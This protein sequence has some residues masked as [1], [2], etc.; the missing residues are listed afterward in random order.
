LHAWRLVSRASIPHLLRPHPSVSHRVSHS[1]CE[2]SCQKA[3][4]QGGRGLHG[5]LDCLA[6]LIPTIG[7]GHTPPPHLVGASVP[8]ARIYIAGQAGRTHGGARDTRNGGLAVSHVRS[9]TSQP[10]SPVP[11][12]QPA[13]LPGTSGLGFIEQL[14]AR[15]NGVYPLCGVIFCSLCGE[16]RAWPSPAPGWPAAPPMGTSQC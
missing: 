4:G 1:L 5:G 14:T 7:Y 11:H 6:A 2:I 10:S 3:V 9:H 13:R 15:K 16:R 12:S 8:S